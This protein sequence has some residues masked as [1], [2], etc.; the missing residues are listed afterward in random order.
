MTTV[1]ELIVTALA[2]AGVKQVW[3]VVG[4]ALNP[5]TD[6]IR[7]DDRIEW[8]G[9]RHEEVAAFA[10][11]AQAQLTGTI[12]VCMG[13]V[14]PG[15]IHLLNG[16]YDAKKSHAPVLAICGQVPTQEIGTD[17]FQEVDNDHL[18]ADVAVF[19]ETLTSPVQLPQLLEQAVN[20][21]YAQHGVAVLT[22]PGDVGDLE[23]DP[24]VATP[25]FAP[26][27]EPAPASMAEVTA[28]AE[29]LT[30]GRPVT[31]LVG[32]GAR[33]ARHE[34]LELADLLAAPMVL[35]LKAKEGLE[36]KN[37]YE[38]GQSGLI[39]N[40]AAA[41]ALDDS[42]VLFLVG[43]DFPYRDWI[44][45]GKTVVQLDARGE[46]I[47]RRT[48]VDHAL[49]GDAATTLE[50]LLQRVRR[51]GRRKDRSHL[52]DAVESYRSWQ[53]R[54]Q[55]L[56]DPG[57]DSTLLGRARAVFDNP[58]SR[59]RPEALAAAVDRA[60]PD[61][62]VFTADT[63]MST[64]WLSRFVT[65]RGGRR[66]LGSFNLGSMANALPMALGAQA[67]D[68]SRPVVSFS[69]DGGLMM[70]L[71]DLRTAVTYQLPVRVVVF[72]NGSLGMVKLEQE[73]GGLPEFGTTL[74][75]PD[76]AAVAAA[77]GLT[78]RRVTENDELE[79]AVQWAFGVDG[80][81]LLD[82]VTNPDEVAVPPQPTLSQAWG[83]AIAK[84]KEVI[85]S[86]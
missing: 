20:A 12:G 76:I 77:L 80:P 18:F 85:E 78:S 52:D 61:D 15:S 64:A 30:D 74:D 70:L 34:I 51:H 55:S 67:L 83:F 23:V 25:R 10:V 72:D 37:P 5:V 56:L 46:H 11:S 6:A 86:R 28:A 31:L 71:G 65:M 63:G 16:L 44:P 38:V 22:L 60:A 66:L 75:N 39:G 50:L 2:D 47:G 33:D 40:P 13:T 17:F 7:R 82:V 73:Q 42:K 21:A 4:D 62:T 54:Q 1:A 29:V 36:Q 84:S 41:K 58:D 81:V 57:H 53:G 3:G 79:D 9:V 8:V 35:T 26:A 32:C 68:R 43:T 27:A 59:I 49:V 48:S 19:A 69:G 14:G 24:D 45:T